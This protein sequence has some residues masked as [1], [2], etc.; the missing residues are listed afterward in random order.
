MEDSSF[1]EKSGKVSL[2][3]LADKFISDILFEAEIGNITRFTKLNLYNGRNRQFS[4]DQNAHMNPP[5][6]NQRNHT[7]I[8][9]QQFK[10]SHMNCDLQNRHL[11]NDSQNNLTN[12]AI[13]E[14]GQTQANLS[15]VEESRNASSY[16]SDFALNV[17]RP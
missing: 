2:S 3:I 16:Y 9:T 14:L 13:V 5:I 4:V 11:Q 8:H 1:F 10:N 17:H 7:V 12:P 15:A 6:D